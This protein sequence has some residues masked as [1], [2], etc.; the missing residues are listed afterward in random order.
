MCGVNMNTDNR[1]FNNNI[2]ILITNKIKVVTNKIFKQENHGDS[3]EM[4]ADPVRERAI[5]NLLLLHVIEETNKKGQLEKNLK[6]QKLVFLI[7]KNLIQRKI[8][9]FTYQFF[10]WHQGPFSAGINA[11]LNLLSKHGLIKWDDN[12]IY[13]TKEGKQVLSSC[14]ELIDK[15]SILDKS[16]NPIL[17]KYSKADPEKLKNYVYQINMFIP[18]LRKVMP[19][20]KIPKRRIILFKPPDKRMVHFFEMNE[21][22][23]ATLELLLNKRGLVSLGKACE[24][25][26]EGRHGEPIRVHTA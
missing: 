25:A 2:F 23:G 10:R 8:K 5:N 22:W 18:I 6:L 16:F 17:D 13:L 1:F 3:G 14:K 19:I 26:K 12:K 7:E 9:A 15:N 24:D 20:E 21:S 4:V 11:D